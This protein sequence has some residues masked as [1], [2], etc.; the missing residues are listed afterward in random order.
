M[1][2]ALPARKGLLLPGTRA[3]KLQFDANSCCAEPT[4]RPRRFREQQRLRALLACGVEP[5]DFTI[6][7]LPNRP[8][9]GVALVHELDLA[10]N[11][12]ER[13]LCDLVADLLAI[14]L[15]SRL[16]CLLGDLQAS[17]DADSMDL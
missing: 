13:P 4:S 12:L 8:G 14:H 1:T 9:M 16:D 7:P 2:D 11:C 17:I 6:L 10:P 3:K 15:T 5:N